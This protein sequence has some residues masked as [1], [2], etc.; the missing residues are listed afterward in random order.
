[1]LITTLTKRDVDHDQP[2]TNIHIDADD[3]DAVIT[4]R[5]WIMRIKARRMSISLPRR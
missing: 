1:M 4:S 2:G 5:S 3:A